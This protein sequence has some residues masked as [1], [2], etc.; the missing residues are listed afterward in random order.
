MSQQTQTLTVHPLLF[1]DQTAV[2]EAGDEIIVP[3]RILDQWIDFFPSGTSMLVRVTA[4][5]GLS[6]IVAIGSTDSSDYIY[7]PQWILEHLGIPDGDQPITVEPYLEELVQAIKLDVRALDS[8][9]DDTDLRGAVERYLDRFHTMEA[10][11]T[12]SVPLED[13]GGY[14]V[15]IYVEAVEPPGPVRLGGEVQLEFLME[16][17]V[18]QLQPE[19][20]EVVAL[21]QAEPEEAVA[22]L[23]PNPVVQ[24]LTEEQKALIREA[25]IKRFNLNAAL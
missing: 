1:L 15:C 22:A 19:P 16:E 3:R 23:Q 4:L 8:V 13:K 5:N 14:Q 10:G 21:P 6:R 25:R 9:E 11:T 12:L 18:A 20:E 2:K 7:A 24:P 17:V